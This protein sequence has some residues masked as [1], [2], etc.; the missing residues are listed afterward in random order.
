MK[1]KNK[2]KRIERKLL[3]DIDKAKYLSDRAL[4]IT[5]YNEFMHS[6]ML[7]ADHDL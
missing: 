7:V 5:T 2:R 6:M 1:I 4:A 3:K